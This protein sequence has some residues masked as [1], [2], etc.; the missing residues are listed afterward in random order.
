MRTTAFLTTT[1]APYIAGP[2]LDVGCGSKPYKPMF[3]EV[4]WIGLDAR[5]VGDV[6]CDMDDHQGT[7]VDPYMTVLCTD[8][9]QYSRDPKR[10]VANMA[11]NL[12]AGG[13]LIIV[14]PN[15]APE[16]GIARWRFT[17]GGLGEMVKLAGL[18]IVY[19]DGLTGLFEDAANDFANSFDISSAL[20]AQFRGWIGHLDQTYPMLSAVIAQK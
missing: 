10:A 2:L 15:V 18:E 9:L 1:A 5:P 16:D 3:P 8:A 14:A 13:H 7:P 17:V 6:E 4:E 20:P 11:S 19:L 12:E